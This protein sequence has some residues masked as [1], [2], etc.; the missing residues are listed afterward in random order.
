L[1]AKQYE[2]YL[3][4]HAARRGNS[5]YA[6][7]ADSDYLTALAAPDNTPY[8]D[9]RVP[10]GAGILN[11][12]Q[13]FFAGLERNVISYG[14]VLNSS[15]TIRTVPGYQTQTQNF[16]DDQAEGRQIGEGRPIGVPKNPTFGDISWGAWDYTS[17][18][19]IVTE[20]QLEMSQYNLSGLISDIQ[21]ERLGRI[22]ARKFTWG[23]GAGEPLG[24][25]EAAKRGGKLVTSV[26]NNALSN[27][28]LVDLQF[29]VDQAFADGPGV[30]YMMHPTT[31][32]MLMKAKDLQGRP[33]FN[34]GQEESQTGIR[35]RRRTLN[36]YPV[37]LNYQMP[38]WAAAAVAVI[39]FG[40]ISKY[41]VVRR[42]TGAPRL[43]RDDTTLR[44]E[45]KTI[46]TTILTADANLRGLREPAD[47]VSERPRLIRL[48]SEPTQA[49][50]FRGRLPNPTESIQCFSGRGQVLGTGRG[51]PGRPPPPRG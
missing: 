41:E 19:V 28:D 11:G 39:L 4:W 24:I 7:L 20:R 22:L 26:A 44:R 50:K 37:Y 47:R 45:L 18:D 32:G 15:V 48:R 33:Y 29:V 49:D 12:P 38:V 3:Q 40:D 43:I 1:T 46:F 13:L 17:D 2:T 6:H 30:G 31:L 27:D 35:T 9:S 14:G 34:I 42:G 16:A 23:K 21:G 5:Q 8:L 25:V 10:D 51:G 36:G